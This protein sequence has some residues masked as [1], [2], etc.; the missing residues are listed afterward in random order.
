MFRMARTSASGAPTSR[1]RRRSP[2]PVDILACALDAPRDDVRDCTSERDGH[3]RM[4]PRVCQKQL[5]G[6]PR[7]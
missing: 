6:G 5:D 4:E 3:G 1:R 7:P 2:R